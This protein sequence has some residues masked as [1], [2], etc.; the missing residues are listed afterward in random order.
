M[1][2]EIPKE[3]LKAIVHEAITDMVFNKVLKKLEILED[4]REYISGVVDNRLAEGEKLSAGIF[5][6]IYE[7][8]YDVIEKWIKH[9]DK[10]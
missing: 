8:C 4:I 10:K 3:E 2:I 1:G 9:K 6:E 7:D 5:D